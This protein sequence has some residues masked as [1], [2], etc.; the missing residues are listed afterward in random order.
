MVNLSRPI[1][2]IIELII[3]IINANN[4]IHLLYVFTHLPNEVHQKK[5][6]HTL[7]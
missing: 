5:F 3:N 4:V 7:N 2:T 1:S 6:L